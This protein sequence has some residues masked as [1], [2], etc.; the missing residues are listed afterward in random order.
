MI[1]TAAK[2]IERELLQYKTDM[3]LAGGGK[4]TYLEIGEGSNADEF[5]NTAT[6]RQKNLLKTGN[7]EAARQAAKLGLTEFN[8]IPCRS[9]GGTLRRVSN[10]RCLNCGGVKKK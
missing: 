2:R 8:G 10:L 7:K 4:I 5:R 9:C 6:D 3:Y 1:N